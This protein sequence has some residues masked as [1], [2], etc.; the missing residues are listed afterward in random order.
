MCDVS[1]T[2]LTCSGITLKDTSE[3]TKTVSEKNTISKPKENTVLQSTN[4][5]EN[6]DEE[7]LVFKIILFI[8][9]GVVLIS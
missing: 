1:T 5:F 6:V 2:F 3:V 8:N 4:P 9:L 7:E